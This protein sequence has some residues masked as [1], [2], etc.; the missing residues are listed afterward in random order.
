MTAGA[1]GSLDQKRSGNSGDSPFPGAMLRWGGRG[2]EHTFYSA[3]AVC[4]TSALPHFISHT[5]PFQTCSHFTDEETEAQRREGDS[6]W[7]SWDVNQKCDPTLPTRVLLFTKHLQCASCCVKCFQGFSSFN[8]H[9]NCMG[10]RATEAQVP[11]PGPT[12]QSH[13]TGPGF[14]TGSVAPEPVLPTHPRLPLLCTLAPSTLR[15]MHTRGTVICLEM[16]APLVETSQV[17]DQRKSL[18][19]H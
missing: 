14:N 2:R 1:Q 18:V 3:P 19:F 11:C 7:E 10:F 16:S 13:V 8:P 6:R 12:A 15:K 9:K 5:S 17:N 4:P